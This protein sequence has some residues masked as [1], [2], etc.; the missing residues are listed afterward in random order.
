MYI[1]YGLFSSG[2]RRISY[3]K[4]D[5]FCIPY[6]SRYEFK[7]AGYL[8]L[9]LWTC[10]TLGIIKCFKLVTN[11]VFGEVFDDVC[12]TYVLT[13]DQREI[14]HAVFVQC[15]HSFRN[16]SLSW[17][18]TMKGYFYLPKYLLSYRKIN[19][20]L[21]CMY[22]SDPFLKTNNVYNLKL[23]LFTNSELA[24]E[25]SQWLEKGRGNPP[26][27]NFGMILR[28]EDQNSQFD[29]L[30]FPMPQ[31][32]LAIERDSTNTHPFLENLKNDANGGEIDQFFSSLELKCGSPSEKELSVL[33]ETELG[34]LEPKL[35][36]PRKR[37]CAALLFMEQVEKWWE[38]DEY[39][40]TE[41]SQIIKNTLDSC[42]F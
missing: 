29:F 42:S 34:K 37:H 22:P 6:G 12:Y 16:V 23:I 35:S 15:K 28:Q 32:S 24:L 7:L 3:Q 5:G 41:N 27:G 39:V 36:N 2:S 4:L 10:F 18:D 20:E 26:Q 14:T 30:N 40:L 11:F 13:G 19:N 31:I 9:R 25:I 38:F 1:M 33:I 21:S 8:F 17:F